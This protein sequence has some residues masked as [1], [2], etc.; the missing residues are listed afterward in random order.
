MIRYTRLAHPQDVPQ[1]V[2]E[3]AAYGVRRDTDAGYWEEICRIV[4]APDEAPLH[5]WQVHNLLKNGKIFYCEK[6][7][8]AKTLI[9]AFIIRAVFTARHC[10]D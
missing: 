2:V 6:L 8:D 7:A 10:L 3:L 5:R 9:E 1:Y 4:K